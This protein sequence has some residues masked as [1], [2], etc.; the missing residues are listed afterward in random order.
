[1]SKQIAKALRKYGNSLGDWVKPIKGRRNFTLQKANSFLVGVLFDQQ[2]KANRA[3]DAA[4]WIT[5]SI[6]ED[7]T[8]FWNCISNINETKLIGFMRFGWAGNAFHRHATKMARYLKGCAQVINTQ[9]QGDP[10]KIWQNTRNI[11]KVRDRF[12]NLPGIGPALSRMAVLILVRNYGSIGGKSA[13]AQLDVKPDD[14]L[15]RVFRRSGLV[16]HN[17]SFDDYLKSAR[18]L[19]PDFP[20]VLDAPAWEIGRNFCSPKNPKCGCCPLDRLCP[21]I[22]VSP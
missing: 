20:A 7:P 6:A 2:V 17:P 12:E 19:A 16:P 3:W 10:R 11:S 15:K 4:E 5:L 22:G 21:K 9:Y 14:L 13:L 8:A 18:K 1:M